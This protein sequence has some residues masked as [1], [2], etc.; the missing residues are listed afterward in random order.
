MQFLLCLLTA[1]AALAS[2]LV[3]PAAAVPV[4]QQPGSSPLDERSS[5]NNATSHGSLEA[6]H[7]IHHGH[8]T[9]YTQNDKE[10]A[11]GGW[12]GDYDSIVAVPSW[13]HDH[14]FRTVKIKAN[15]ITKYAR[16]VDSCD[17]CDPSQLDMSLGLFQAFEDLNVGE[18]DIEWGFV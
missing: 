12:Y 5:S 7:R 3:Q 14:C 4:T 18:F 17:S 2:L 13:H 11:C 15:G 10:V 9:W 1:F 6:R 8:A 16:A